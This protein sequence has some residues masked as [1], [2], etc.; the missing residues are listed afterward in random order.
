MHETKDPMTNAMTPHQLSATVDGRWLQPPAASML[1]EQCSGQAVIDSRQVEPGD[2]FWAMPGS[3][4]H[5]A[6][7]I[8]DAL[9]RGACGIV[10]DRAEAE[11][12]GQAWALRVAN[13]SQALWQ[14]AAWQRE[15]FSGSVIGITGSVGKTTTR[16][17]IDHVLAGRYWGTASPRNYNNHI[18]V[19]LSMLAWRADHDYAVLEMGASAAGEIARLASLARPHI[20]VITRIAEAHLASFRQPICRGQGQG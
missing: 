5:G 15:Q 2:I 18:G 3:T 6:D 20:A 9:R 16:Q 14:A 11:T 12:W 13:P 4:R 7:F 1:D 17:L 10:T 8:G 19:P